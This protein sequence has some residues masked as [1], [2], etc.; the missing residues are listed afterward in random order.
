VAHRATYCSATQSRSLS[1]QSGH[2]MR[3]ATALL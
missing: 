3:H 2:S 1:V